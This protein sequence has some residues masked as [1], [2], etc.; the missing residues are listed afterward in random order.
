MSHGDFEP[1]ERAQILAELQSC[2]VFVD[3]G[4]NVGFYTCLARSRGRYVVAVEPLADNL[5]YLYMNLGANGWDDVEIFPLGLAE[6]PGVLTLYGRSTAASLVPSW[7]QNT[8]AE[9]RSIAVSTLDTILGDRFPGQRLLIK[10][11]VEGAEHSVLAGA[12]A[13]LRRQP[14]PVWVAEVCFS[15]H[16]PGGANP[17]FQDVFDR[18][19]DNGYEAFG[20]EPGGLVAIGRAQVA[21]WVRDRSRE[22]GLMSYVF[23]GR[24]GG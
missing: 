17:H 2:D 9:S 6:H 18:F 5:D 19:W 11:D 1:L 10:M 4:A 23:R 7:A 3:I 16:H 22:Y 15:E 14:A 20:I 8:A 13:T 12:T 21:E 24:P